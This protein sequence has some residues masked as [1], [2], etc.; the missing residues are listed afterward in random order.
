MGFYRRVVLPFLMDQTMD[1]EELRGHRREL[2]ATARGQ[3]L[4]IGFGSG[5]NAPFYPLPAVARVTAVDPNA[6]MQR[7]AGRRIAA[8]AVPIEQRLG[9][10]ERLPVDD[11]SV[12]CVVTSFVL[13][14]VDEIDRTLAEIARVL[15]PDGRYLLLEHGLSGDPKLQKWQ[16]R[17]DSLQQRLAGGCHL[18]R[19]IR[20]E[21]E[22]AGF[23]FEIARDFHLREGP[24]VATFCTLG[25]AVR[26]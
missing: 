18:T 3:V 8:A 21:I 7:R 20:A 19:P 1:R 11:A 5:L 6:G 10:G 17:L 4:E 23:R 16:R 25:A 2:L 14:S 22:R 13:C 15:K 9:S 24:R 26:R 12:D